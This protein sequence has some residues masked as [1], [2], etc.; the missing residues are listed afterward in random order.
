MCGLAGCLPS[1]GGRSRFTRPAGGGAVQST[2]CPV[3]VLY[4]K[5]FEC[6][7]CGS[8]KMSATVATW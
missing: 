8:G 5:Q 1:L 2:R 6:E 3:L 7:S 4:Y